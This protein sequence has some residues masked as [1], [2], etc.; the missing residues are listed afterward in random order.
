MRK[1]S[2]ANYKF[3]EADDTTNIT[4]SRNIT[5]WG[6]PSGGVVKC[7]HSASAAR[8]SLVRIPGADVASLGKPCVVGVPRIK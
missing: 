6:Q 2:T 3:L 1:K 5:S 8:G 4:K 7:A